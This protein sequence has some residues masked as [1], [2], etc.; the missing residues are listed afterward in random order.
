MSLALVCARALHNQAATVCLL[1]LLEKDFG[2]L[3]QSLRLVD[4]SVQSLSS[5]KDRLD[6]LVE[7]DL[8]L[9]ELLLHSHDSVGLVGI[10][11]SLNV[12]IELG[13]AQLGRG[14]HGI[15]PLSLGVLGEVLLQHLVEQ[16][17]G[18]SNGVLL[19][20]DDDTA[21]AVGSQVRVANVGVLLDGLSL[22]RLC[23]GDDGLGQKGEG[24]LVATSLKPGKGG[25]IAGAGELHSFGLVW[26]KDTD[27]VEL[28]VE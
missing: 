1:G 11:V 6:G 18:D 16:S 4:K 10:L 3:R 17:V 12:I 27:V 13:H 19:V 24:L 22:S 9:V 14:F 8:G 5:G 20:G 28:H 7:H 26:S 23:S 2:R 21:N 25:E 15:L